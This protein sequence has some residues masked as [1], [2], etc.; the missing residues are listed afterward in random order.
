[1]LPKAQLPVK[2]F[3]A[4]SRSSREH[5]ARR[6]GGPH[7]TGPAIGNSSR[8]GQPIPGLCYHDYASGTDLMSGLVFGRLG[9]K[10]AAAWAKG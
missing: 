1:M 4:R 9:G 6:Q 2:L 3:A 7:T 8:P 5:R 10:G